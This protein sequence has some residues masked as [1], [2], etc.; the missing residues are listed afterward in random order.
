MYKVEFNRIYITSGDSAFLK[1]SIKDRL[2]Q[3]YIP[4]DDDIILFSVKQSTKDKR[5][6]FQKRINNTDLGVELLPL[7]TKNLSPGRYIY[8]VQLMRND[9]VDTIISPSPFIITGEVTI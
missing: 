7:D 6:L 5:L 8:D 1:L 2:G 3:E 4:K 9:I